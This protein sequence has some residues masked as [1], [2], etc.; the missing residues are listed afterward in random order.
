M[1][2][3][4]KDVKGF[5]GF[6]QVSNLGNVF[7]IKKNKI[8]KPTI[9]DNGYLQ[10][11]LYK[12]TEHKKNNIHRLVAIA[13]IPNPYNLPQVNHK[14]EDKT[15]NNVW[16]L[17][18][19]TCKENI[20]HGTHNF[21]SGIKH[22]KPINQYDLQG[23]FIKSWNSGTEIQ[24]ETGFTHTNITKCCKGHTKTAYGFIWQYA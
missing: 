15:N 9:L 13:F 4:Y 12:N 21:R 19:C 3:I 6:Y 5:E 16:N 8:L 7:S 24:K 18:W 23:N 11:D 22:R 14:D 1:E 10:V 20:N 17:E 2:E